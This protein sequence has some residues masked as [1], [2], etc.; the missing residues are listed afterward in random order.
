MARAIAQCICRKCGESF[1]KMKYGCRNRSEANSWEE[2]AESNIDL[3][4]ECWKKEQEEKKINDTERYEIK[5][6]HYSEYKNKYS[7]CKTVIDSYNKE[8]KTIKVIIDKVEEYKFHKDKL[9]S[10]IKEYIKDELD[11]KTDIDYIYEVLIN[12]IENS[13]LNEEDKIRYNEKLTEIYF[14]IKGGNE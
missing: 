14:D 8:T 4:T 1:E 2:W 13:K 11:K 12:N 3:C 7:W 10:A 9:N 6:M 5:E